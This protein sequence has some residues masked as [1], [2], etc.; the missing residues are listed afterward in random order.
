MKERPTSIT[1]A[2]RLIRVFVMGFLSCTSYV[3]A[4]PNP[5]NQSFTAFESGQVRPLSM[6]PDK[7]YLLAVNTPDAKLEIF[8]IKNDGLE[9]E[10]QSLLGWNQFRSQPAITKKRG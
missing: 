8:K 1:D 3:L 9:L 2:D 4:Q 5:Y 7:R 6:T 10:F